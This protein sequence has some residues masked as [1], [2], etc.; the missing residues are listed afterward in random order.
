MF[1]NSGAFAEFCAGMGTGL[2][3]YEGLR[4]ALAKRGFHARP[5]CSCF[6][7]KMPW[8]AKAL[9]AIAGGL[10]GQGPPPTVFKTASSLLTPNADPLLDYAGREV[11]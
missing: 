2:I 1:F 9:E 7:E 11:Q 6:T 4:R 5:H 10:D 8:K 3:C